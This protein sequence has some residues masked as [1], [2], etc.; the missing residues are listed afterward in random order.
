MNCKLQENNKRTNPMS[1]VS[2]AHGRMAILS[3][4]CVNHALMYAGRIQPVIASGSNASSRYVDSVK[5]LLIHHDGSLNNL[6]IQQTAYAMLATAIMALLATKN[7]RLFQS[8]QEK[9]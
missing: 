8:S 6:N 7:F 1:I 2:Y 4:F 9:Q 3:T 5:T